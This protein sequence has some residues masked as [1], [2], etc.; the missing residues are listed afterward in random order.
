[1]RSIIQKNPSARTGGGKLGHSAHPALPDIE[2]YDDVALT[3]I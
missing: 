2:I 3:V 1:M